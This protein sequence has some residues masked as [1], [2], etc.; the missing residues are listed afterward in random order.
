MHTRNVLSKTKAPCKSKGPPEQTHTRT[1][2]HP[3][4]C[5]HLSWCSFRNCTTLG[6]ERATSCV[7]P[8]GVSEVEG[9]CRD[10][11]VCLG[12]FFLTTGFDTDDRRLAVGSVARAGGLPFLSPALLRIPELGLSAPWMGPRSAKLFFRT[13]SALRDILATPCT[14]VKISVLFSICKI[15]HQVF[16]LC[17]FCSCHEW[18]AAAR[19]RAQRQHEDTLYWRWRTKAWKMMQMML[20]TNHLLSCDWG[21]FFSL[22]FLDS[23]NN[24]SH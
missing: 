11:R 3:R 16:L 23:K 2:T 8:R 1:T 18:A 20:I 5:I 12:G 9:L 19:Y 10:R 7:L 22:F 21:T 6:S 15:Q 24:D 14:R 4:V 13:P 17:R